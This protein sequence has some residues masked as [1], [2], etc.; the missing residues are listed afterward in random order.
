MGLGKSNIV[1]FV[2]TRNAERSREF[3]EKTLGLTFV[4]DDKFALVFE[5]N[6]IQIRVFRAP[7]YQPFNFTILGWEVNDIV[8]T[9]KELS[10]AGVTFERYSFIEQDELG[11]WSAPDRAAKIAWFK[12][13]EGNSLSVS[14]H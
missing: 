7:E 12:D 8:A 2:P 14:Q 9:V 4:S 6:G 13:P 11:I 3:F 10:A 5:S 1:G